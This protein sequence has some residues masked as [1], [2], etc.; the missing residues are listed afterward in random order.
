MKFEI[1][2]INEAVEHLESQYFY[3]TSLWIFYFST[4]DSTINIVDKHSINDDV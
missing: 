4:A 3:D 2:K 1:F